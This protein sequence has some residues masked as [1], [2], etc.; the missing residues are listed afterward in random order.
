[1]MPRKE[2]AKIS[3][4]SI[5]NFR[6]GKMKG[7]DDRMFSPTAS[8]LLIEYGEKGWKASYCLEN[9]QLQ[10][11]FWYGHSYLSV[12]L[13]CFQ[14]GFLSEKNGILLLSQETSW[15]L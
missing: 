6:V 13:V 15:Y 11:L 12:I 8:C 4:K 5:K 10:L 9:S 14:H 3:S 1:M 7:I 2:F